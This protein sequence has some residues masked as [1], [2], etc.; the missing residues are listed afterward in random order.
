MRVIVANTA[1][2]SAPAAVAASAPPATSVAAQMNALQNGAIQIVY[3]REMRVGKDYQ[4]SNSALPKPAARVAPERDHAV[5]VWNPDAGLAEL[6]GF[7]DFVAFA[8]TK[9]ILDARQA[10]QGASQRLRGGPERDF[11]AAG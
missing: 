4:C 10:V 3:K 1:A 5:P 11:A 2:M 9:G 7:G 6:D 8:R